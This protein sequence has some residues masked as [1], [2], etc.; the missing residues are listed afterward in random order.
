MSARKLHETDTPRQRL[1]RLPEVV[2]IT[3]VSRS[4]LYR[5]MVASTFP[6]PIK[7]GARLSAWPADEVYRWVDTQIAARS[8]PVPRARY[9][10]P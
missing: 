9:E 10:A 4:E 7:L 1:L 6:L 8:Q 3:G 5:R 2:A